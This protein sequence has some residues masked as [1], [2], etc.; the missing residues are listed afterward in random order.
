MTR[1]AAA[2]AAVALSAAVRFALDPWLEHDAP[3]LVFLFGVSVA[4]LHG[5]VAPGLLATG[6]GLLVGTF[7]FIEPRYAIVPRG[8]RDVV[9]IAVFAAE[10]ALIAYLSGRLRASV[11]ATQAAAEAVRQQNETLE[12]QVRARTAALL[13]SNQSLER[14][15]HVV[16]HDVRAPLTSIRGLAQILDED[17]AP[18]LPAEGR[19]Y[20]RRLAAAAQR[21]DALVTNLLTYARLDE[22]DAPLAPVSIDEAVGRIVERMRDEIAGSGA[23]VVVKGP[24]G[25]VSGTDEA[26]TLILSNLV[27]NALKFVPRGAAPQVTLSSERRD[28][29]LRITVA[30]AG[31][32]VDPEQQQRIFEPFVRLHDRSAYE[33]TGLG[34]ALVARAVTRLGGRYGVEPGT[35]GGSRFWVE[36]KALD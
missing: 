32:G 6:A 15:A 33:G 4:A 19:N 26:L 20:A 29:Y 1:Y 21:L 9:R 16:T 8:D 34:L 5:G 10:G 14:F 22:G 27:A 3:L 2:L 35:G 13:A 17:Y 24:L 31:I 28:A 30:D 11:L 7:L 12:A 36:L 18:A 25:T 23:D